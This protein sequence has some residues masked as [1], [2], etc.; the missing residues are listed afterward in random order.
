MHAHLI[1]EWIH[2]ILIQL[3]PLQFVMK[4]KMDPTPNASLYKW[5]YN[6]LKWIMLKE[7]Q[8]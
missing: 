4:G 1:L 5:R 3:A 8:K 2:D 6:I 7:E